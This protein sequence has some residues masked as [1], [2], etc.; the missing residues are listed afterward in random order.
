MKATD[1][2]DTDRKPWS[3][4]QLLA[5]KHLHSRVAGDSYKKRRGESAKR[6]RYFIGA[7]W[8]FTLNGPLVES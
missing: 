6:T 4:I 7:N 3:C 2:G 8:Q 5:Y 1:P